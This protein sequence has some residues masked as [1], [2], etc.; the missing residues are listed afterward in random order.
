MDLQSHESIL[1]PH[2]VPS[3]ITVWNSCIWVGFPRSLFFSMSMWHLLNAF[4]DLMNWPPWPMSLP[5]EKGRIKDH[6]AITY[7]IMLTLRQESHATTSWSHFSLTW[8]ARQIRSVGLNTHLWCNKVTWTGSTWWCRRRAR[9]PARCRWRRRR[10]CAACCAGCGCGCGGQRRTTN[11]GSR[12]RC[13]RRWKC[14]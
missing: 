14:S 1:Y 3:N 9:C 13:C 11:W 10:R 5:A 7:L 4:T 8:Q 6:L 12:S 2:L